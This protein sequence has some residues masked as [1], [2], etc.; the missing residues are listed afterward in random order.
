MRMVV[1]PCF[2]TGN[3]IWEIFFL[4]LTQYSK[5]APPRRRQSQNFHKRFFEDAKFRLASLL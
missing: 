1:F 3:F 2:V 4:S 5:V